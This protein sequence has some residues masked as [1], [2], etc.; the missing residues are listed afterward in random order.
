MNTLLKIVAG[1]TLVTLFA[2]PASAI[3]AQTTGD[4]DIDPNADIGGVPPEQIPTIGA[5]GMM[6][7]IRKII[8]WVFT[9]LLVVVFIMMLVAAFMFVTGGGNPD[10]VSKARQIL[11]MALV[12]FAVAMLAQGVVALVSSI[13]GGS[14]NVPIIQTGS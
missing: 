9:I 2:V 10:S 1:I 7:L 13:L 8:N 11:I 5:E 14:G 6:N 4:V 12:G 3:F